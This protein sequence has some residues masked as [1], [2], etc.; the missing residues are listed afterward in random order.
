MTESWV[1]KYRPKSL[2]EIIGQKKGLK[3]LK[4]WYNDWNPSDKPL[5]LHG[6]PGTGK[7]S[8]ALA[9]GNEENL[10][11]IEI[12]ASDKRNR[13]NIEEILGNAAKQRSLMRKGKLILVDEV[14]GLSGREDRGGIGAISR[15]IKDSKFPILMTA[16]DPYDKKMRSLRNKCKLVNFGN[17]HLNSMTAKLNEICE[18]EGIEADRKVLKSIARKGGRDLRSAINDLESV[19]RG[20]KK[21]TKEDV[22]SIGYRENKH[23]I[24][25]VLKVIF[26]TETVK[27]SLDIMNNT[28]K[29]PDEIFWWIEQNIPK[30]YKKNKEVWK[31][32]D[33]L[34]KSDIF[35]GRIRRMQNWALYKYFIDFMSAGVSMS[36]E[37][38]Y[39]T[40]TRYSPPQ[41]L[42]RY[43]KSK[44]KR[45]DVSNLSK[46]IGD[47]L[48]CSSKVVKS[49]YFP[50]IKNILENN[51]KMG[52]KI[53]E[54]LDMEENELDIIRDW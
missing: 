27:T 18:N 4:K 14:D 25:D 15:I 50:M 42:I 53:K 24:F 44:G 17:V 32:Y 21:L 34:S 43:G 5:I 49:A 38:K 48:H 10:D 46:K 12:N 36:K 1:D 8:A 28:E 52:N 39:R 19:T 35:K 2:N 6:P 54:D 45:K 51:T 20:K 3:K 41:R 30:E 33:Y 40:F 7:T 9:L 16:N 37:K 23:E 26:K 22:S 29:N 31:A 11:I 13:K 47:R